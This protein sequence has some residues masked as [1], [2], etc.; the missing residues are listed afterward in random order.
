VQDCRGTFA[1]G[2]C[3]T[4]FVTPNGWSGIT[5]GPA[6]ASGPTCTTL[7]QATTTPTS[8]AACADGNYT[9]SDT[10]VASGTADLGGTVRQCRRAPAARCARLRLVVRSL[11]S[12]DPHPALARDVETKTV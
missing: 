8:I 5:L 9:F 4:G 7:P 1:N 2:S 3:S 12:H 10:V 11:P 6:T